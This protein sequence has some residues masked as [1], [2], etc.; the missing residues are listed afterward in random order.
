MFLIASK[1]QYKFSGYDH[2]ITLKFGV[3]VFTWKQQMGDHISPACGPD[4]LLICLQM[5]FRVVDHTYLIIDLLKCYKGMEKQTCAENSEDFFILCCCLQNFQYNSWEAMHQNGTT[6][7]YKILTKQRNGPAC[8][9]QE[10]SIHTQL[11]FVARL[12]VY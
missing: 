2:P 8:L 9:K 7:K 1:N 11:V 3:G 4:S 10:H 12:H 6:I 5:A